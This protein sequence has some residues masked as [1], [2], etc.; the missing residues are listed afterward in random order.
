MSISFPSETSIRAT[1]ATV[2]LLGAFFA[3]WW[4]PLACM[5]MLAIRY[6]AWEALV[7]GLIMDFLWLPEV[8]LHI[9]KF[10]IAGIVLVWICAPL[11]NQ[12]LRP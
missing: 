11:R 1:L 9:P 3:P 2:G 10:L 12:F 8:G 6:P 4:V 5:I 7:I